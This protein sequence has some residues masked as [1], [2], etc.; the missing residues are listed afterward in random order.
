MKQANHHTARI[1]SAKRS[2]S[3]AKLTQENAQAIRNGTEPLRVVADRYAI[4]IG[5]A[6]MIRRGLRRRDFDSPFAG[7]MT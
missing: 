2:S 6:S 7:L 4:S 5:H 1:A 3:Q